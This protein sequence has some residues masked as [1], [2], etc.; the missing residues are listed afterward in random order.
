VNASTSRLSGFTDSRDGH[1]YKTVRI[2]N[3]TWMAENLAYKVS[4]GCWAYENKDNY[5]DQFGFLYNWQTAQNVCPAGWH[6]PSDKEW[7][8]LAIFV[9]SRKGVFERETDK[10]I[11]MGK[12]LKATYRWNNNENGDDYFGF[13]GLPG[14]YRSTDGSFTSLGMSG[15]W[16][17]STEYGASTSLY[18]RIDG[19]NY[20]YSLSFG[21]RGCFSVRCI[22]D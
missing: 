4:N 15:Y 1:V 11:E 18:R 20:F 3:Q 9:N 6:L 2:G 17:S 5:V 13:T 10:W 16:W 7:E 22:K 21:K 8:T 19:S 12:Y 14:G